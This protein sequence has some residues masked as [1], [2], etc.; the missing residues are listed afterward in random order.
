[1]ARRIRSSRGGPDPSLLSVLLLT[2]VAACAPAGEG[3]SRT[4]VLL[5][6]LDS[7]RR[8][9]LGAYGYDSELAPGVSPT[10]FLDEVAREGV[11]FDG[12]V[13][14]SSWTLP[15]HVSLLTGEP[16]LVHAVELDVYRIDDGLPTLAETLGADGYRTA[17]FYSGP[18]LHPR[19]GFG[20]G[21]ERY[22]ECYG[23]ELA[24]AAAEALAAA[25]RV[26]ALE[27]DGMTPQLLDAFERN[28]RAQER[29]E[30]VSH[31]DRS[32][33]FVADAAI[34]ELRAAASGDRPF[35][36][37][38]HF[39]DPHF[40]YDPPAPFDRRFDPGYEGTIRGDSF[41][42]DPRISVPD[43]SVPSG[44]RRVASDRDLAHVRALYAGDLAHT[45]A[46]IGRIL[47]T[48][49]ELGL[50]EQTLVVVVADHG[51]E[52][53]E[54][55]GIG[56]RRTLFEEV[57]AVPLFLRLPGRLSAGERVDEPVSIADLRDTVLTLLAA[58]GASSGGLLPLIEGR[59]GERDA[60]R[61]GVL[62]RLVLSR[63]VPVSVPDG[64]TVPADG[65]QVTESFRR[66]GV[67]IVRRRS[68][69]KAPAN[70]GESARDFVREQS[71]RIFDDEQ[72]FWIDLDRHPGEPLDAYSDDFSD[73]RALGALEAFRARYAELSRR[74]RDAEVEA[75]GSE[76]LGALRGLGYG[77]TRLGEPAA[78][79]ELVLPAPGDAILRR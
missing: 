48:L 34:D 65:I 15:S 4:H 41:F 5:I 79:A 45:D 58:R 57:V 74:R 14:T 33:K 66:G 49:D 50:R 40:D 32:S 77:D 2:A 30:R 78:S 27:G 38:A 3:T 20:R 25:Q 24:A 13:A 69:M 60:G 75:G 43:R 73:E 28:V 72:L 61:R 47:A 26:E 9:M 67:K 56:H 16:D 68:W 22:E 17:G 42:T 71:K 46:Q 70:V 54:H 36:L 59:A 44:R 31:R 51:D 8:D 18:Y 6:S 35:F 64:S 39:F 37:F 12:A 11:V 63:P 10:P 29:L 19:F 21:F 1:M 23:E 7:T 53:F 62:S 52:F 76:A 55:G